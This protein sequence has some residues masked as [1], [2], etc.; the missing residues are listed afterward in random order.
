MR[1]ITEA[2]E[3]V[4]CLLKQ[5]VSAV[6]VDA[7]RRV[8]E[9]EW[10]VDPTIVRGRFAGHVI[11]DRW[12]DWPRVLSLMAEGPVE[13]SDRRT[14]CDERETVEAHI[15]QMPVLTHVHPCWLP[16]E[17]RCPRWRSPA[18]PGLTR[19]TSVLRIRDVIRRRP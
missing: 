12:T 7:L 15:R 16:P 17:L 10:V 11:P 4:G 3:Q 9:G 2:P 8:V 5:R 14:S 18:L 1:L 19:K 13:W 6:I